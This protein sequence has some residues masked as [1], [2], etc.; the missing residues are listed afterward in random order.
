MAIPPETE[1]GTLPIHRRRRHLHLRRHLHPAMATLVET[2]TATATPAETATRVGT[3][4][5]TRVAMEMASGATRA[6][7][8]TEILAT[9]IMGM[10]ELRAMPVARARLRRH[11]RPHHHLLL[12]H[13][14][15]GTGMAIRRRAIR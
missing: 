8:A 14:L 12:R 15:R 1:M 4:T 13:R 2:G 11:R 10:A 7:W 6:Q 9:E 5:A 3:E